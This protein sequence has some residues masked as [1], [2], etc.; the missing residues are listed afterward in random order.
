M[1]RA[2]GKRC[3]SRAPVDF[4]ITSLRS[5]HYAGVVQS[6]TSFPK[7]LCD[8]P[9]R[10]WYARCLEGDSPSKGAPPM[11]LSTDPIAA[12]SLAKLASE[13]PARR[14]SSCATVWTSAARP[15][16]AGRRMRRGRPRPPRHRGRARRRVARR[17]RLRG[18][19]GRPLEA[20]IDHVLERFHARHRAELPP[21]IVLGAQRRG[22]PCG[23]GRVPARP[24]KAPGA[25]AE[26]LELHMQKEEQMLFPLIRQGRGR[27]ALMPVQVMEEEHKDHA[28]QPRAA[29]RPGGR[30]RP[31]RRGAAR[32]GARWSSGSRELER[33]L[34][35]AHPSREQRPLPARAAG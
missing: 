5:A 9:L 13:Q 31:S 24:G 3:S 25:H 14:S 17:P 8:R 29:A 27:M 30:L 19:E 28:P 34:I 4:P 12:Q 6:A 11:P 26:E 21:L 16:L 23:Q 20:L 2:M 15:D 33:A 35:A 1:S 22:A 18:W 7:S 32:P 10:T